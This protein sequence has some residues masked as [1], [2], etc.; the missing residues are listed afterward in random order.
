MIKS[1]QLSLCVQL[2]VIGA[3][4][5]REMLTRYGRNNIGFLWL[6]VE[7]MIFTLVMVA[8]WS[9]RRAGM[10]ISVV[11]FAIT[12][13]PVAMI[14]RNS[15]SRGKNA[16]SPNNALLYHRNVKV[17]DIFASRIL[18]EITGG[19]ASFLF[20]VI[21]FNFTGS[22]QPPED[23]LKILF[24]LLLMAWFGAALAM[25]IGSLT[26]RSE[27]V[28][29]LWSPFSFFLFISSGVFFLVDWLPP[30]AQQYI[31]WLPMVHG[32]ELVRDGYFGRLFTAHYDVAY[33]TFWNL[34][35]TLLGLAMLRQA[36]R[37]VELS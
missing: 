28:D 16:I 21:I 37:N 12:G 8:I 24:G 20:L 3:L 11:M 27:V 2:R 14:W 17:L 9:V 34:F 19:V 6:F 30:V 31:L 22:M 5:R 10:D 26:E 4:L 7:P 33:L 32:I 15:V 36:G 29:K 35:L 18:L 23:I 1:L 13:Y 25:V